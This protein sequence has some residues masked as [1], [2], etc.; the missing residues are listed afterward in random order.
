VL[1]A[2]PAGNHALT[3]AQLKPD[4]LPEPRE[5]KPGAAAGFRL[6][7]AAGQEIEILQAW[8]TKYSHNGKAAYAYDFG[9]LYR[10]DVLAAAPG[11]VAFVHAG[12]RACGGPELRNKAN[13]VTIYHADGF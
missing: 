9:L 7:F 11:V 6:P 4:P 13:Y 12:E 10:T 2:A 1:A 3:P 8:N 5:Q